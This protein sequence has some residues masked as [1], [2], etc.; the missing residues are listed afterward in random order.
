MTSQMDIQY[1]NIKPP[2]DGLTHGHLRAGSWSDGC[3]TFEYR[4]SNIEY[5]SV[6][7][8]DGCLILEYRISISEVVRWTFDIRISNTQLRA[9]QMDV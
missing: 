1:S 5:P 4:I 6:G 9:C 7:L 3:L 2:S 8:S